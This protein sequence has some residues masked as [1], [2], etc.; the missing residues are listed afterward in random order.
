VRHVCALDATLPPCACTAPCCLIVTTERAGPAGCGPRA[1]SEGWLQWGG[2]LGRA[3]REMGRTVGLFGVTVHAQVGGDRPERPPAQ[4]A[5][6]PPVDDDH[7]ADRG[8]GRGA[9][10]QHGENRRERRARPAGRGYHAV[11]LGGHDQPSGL[12]PNGLRPKRAQTKTSHNET[13][14]C[15]A[16]RHGH[17]AATLHTL[18]VTTPGAP[19]P[20][21]CACP[22]GDPAHARRLP[23]VRSGS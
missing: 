13:T 22:G 19:G 8:E 4:M 1:V 10:R 23:R 21:P 2:C 7:L 18:G 3:A 14:Q 15:R 20:R 11:R 12:R 6:H 17:P 9:V 5:D 16:C